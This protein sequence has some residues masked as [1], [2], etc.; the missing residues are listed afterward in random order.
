MASTIE[1]ASRAKRQAVVSK[2]V[3]GLLFMTMG[4]LFMLENLGRLDLSDQGRY[5]AS[6][7]VDGD[8]GTRWSSAFSDPQWIAVD[9]GSAAEITQV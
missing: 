1:L 7:A 6:N 8:P 2:V 9:L 5:P 4:V 3:W